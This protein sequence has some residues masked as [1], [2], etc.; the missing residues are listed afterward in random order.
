LYSKAAVIT[1]AV[2]N[3]VVISEVQI[4]GAGGAN[5]DFVELYNPTDTPY[6]LNGHRIVKRTAD[7]TSDTSLKSWTSET[8]IPANG[9]YLWANSS[10]TPSV[11]ADAST[12][13]TLA[14]NNGVALRQGAMDTG[15]I[16][17]SVAWGTVTNAF[18]EGTPF[19]TN[20]AAGESL[21]RVGDDTD[22]NS[23]DFIIQSSPNPQNS[24]SAVSPTPTE[25]VSPTPT[26][27]VS[28]TPTEEVTPTPTSEP[29]A[30]GDVVI[31]EVA[32]SGTVA[33][34]DDEWIELY[35]NT[36]SSVDL[37]DWTLNALDGTP[38]ITLSGT[39]PG[40][41]Y[42]LLERGD[43][44]VS[45][46]TADQVYS[47]ALGNTGES[48][49]LRNS[50]GDLVDTA[51]SDGGGWPAG[52]STNRMSM[53][54]ID[55]TLA[56]TDDNWVTNVGVTING[57]D[58]LGNAILGTPKEVNSASTSSPTPTPTEEVTPTPTEEVSPT[59][60]EE[61]SPT[62]TEQPSPTPTEEASPTPTEEV[63]PTPTLAPAPPPFIL[64]FIGFGARTKVCTIQYR[65]KH[66]AFFW[67]FIPKVSCHKI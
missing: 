49:E 43:D 14:A 57:L 20:P 61:V 8:L 46:I 16:I 54:R 25:G 65:V 19:P 1:K 39:I 67:L 27:E 11:T 42:F 4:A 38:S 23:V 37:T 44:A 5:E 60:T 41:G 45:D 3:H 51:N 13:A 30:S 55:P 12:S 63:S 26:E 62:P 40:N 9:Y 22:N 64:G 35:N 58:A 29:T 36:A 31:N 28:P 56:D 6:D 47:G 52:D 34:A 7:G 33:S 48:L 17:D 18:I 59:P 32:W 53:E 10:W 66:V 21:E 2:T 15:I 24:S 50:T